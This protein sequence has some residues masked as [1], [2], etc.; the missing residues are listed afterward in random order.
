VQV[1]AGETP[2]SGNYVITQVSHTLGRST[3][4]QSFRMLRNAST[5]TARKGAVDQSRRIA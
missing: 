3:Y 5:G 1:L 2:L 4:T